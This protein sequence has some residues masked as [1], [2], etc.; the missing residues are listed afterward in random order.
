MGSPYKPTEGTAP[1][2]TVQLDSAARLP[3]VDGSQL[4]NLPVSGNP[5]IAAAVV[6]A[7]QD[8]TNGKNIAGIAKNG[9]GDYTIALTAN[10][11]GKYVP[12]VSPG[13]DCGQIHVS[14]TD[15]THFHVTGSSAPP[16][17]DFS[18]TFTLISA[19]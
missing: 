6:D 10:T 8:F 15:A 18:F 17:G 16:G 14:K 1:F 19:D 7:A 5:I 2:S 13:D 11:S 3:A 12:Q 9:V 4:T